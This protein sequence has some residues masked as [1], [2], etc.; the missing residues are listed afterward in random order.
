MFIWEELQNHSV[1]RVLVCV[2]CELE[3]C[4]VC[5]G[6]LKRF[7]LGRNCYVNLKIKKKV[8]SQSVE[9]KHY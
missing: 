9:H 7:R 5:I 4:E 1:S 8:M 2:K 6:T 3:M